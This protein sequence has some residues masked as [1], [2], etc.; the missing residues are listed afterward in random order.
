MYGIRCRR[1]R[2]SR[3]VEEDGRGRTR[4]PIKTSFYILWNNNNLSGFRKKKKIV[5]YNFNYLINYFRLSK[6]SRGFNCLDK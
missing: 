5:S 3:E 2:Y 6:I 1:K 4:L